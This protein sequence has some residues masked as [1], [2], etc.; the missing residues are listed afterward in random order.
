LLAFLRR[1]L[2]FRQQYQRQEGMMTRIVARRAIILAAIGLALNALAWCRADQPGQVSEFKLEWPDL[3]TDRAMH[4]E[5]KPIRT[6]HEIT[7]PRDGTSFWITGGHHDHVA[8]VT[9]EGKAEFFSTGTG[10]HPHGILFDEDGRLW[11]SLEGFGVVAR[12]DTNGK[13]DKPID[14]RLHARGAEKPINTNPHGLGLDS[15]G[16]TIWFT[17]KKTNTVGRIHRDGSV[18]HFELPTEGAVPIY[19]SPGPNKHNT[20]WCTELVANRIARISATGKVDEFEICTG[21]SRPIA[22]VEGPDKKAMWFSE[23][24]GHKVARIDLNGKITEYPVPRTQKNVILAGMTFD[25][26]G[27]LWTQSYVNPA[28]PFPAGSD[29]IIRIDKAIL[30]APAGDLSNVPVTFFKVPST[31]TVMHRIVQG[32]DDNIWFTE[33]AVDQLGKLRIGR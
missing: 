21:N 30:G 1:D 32:P 9:L 15:D 24:A 25:R 28:D 2:V 29:H 13:I 31:N 33:L 17:G 19:L 23:E 14:V 18:Q 12:L 5:A 16:R 20:M 10:S 7:Y 4:P 27:N 11:V 8:R 3:K 22:I 6:T 26:D